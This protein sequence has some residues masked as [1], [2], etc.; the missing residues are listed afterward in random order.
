M[1]GSSK[2]RLIKS[3]LSRMKANIILL[4]KTKC[5]KGNIRRITQTIWPGCESKWIVMEGASGGISTL[6]DLDMLEM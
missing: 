3:K 4:Q 6:C 1:N 5:D 2:Q